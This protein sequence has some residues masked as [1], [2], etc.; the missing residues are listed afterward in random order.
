MLRDR[1]PRVLG[2]R[3][4]LH[5]FAVYARSGECRK[6]AFPNLISVDESDLEKN[7]DPSPVFERSPSSHCTISLKML[8]SFLEGSMKQIIREV[9]FVE[10]TGLH[11]MASEKTLIKEFFYPFL[12]R[13][14]LTRLS[15]WWEMKL[16]FKVLTFT[17]TRYDGLKLGECYTSETTLYVGE[18]SVIVTRR[19]G[20]PC[21]LKYELVVTFINRKSK[22][23]GAILPE[24]LRTA[25][26]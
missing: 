24:R 11:A 16:S 7:P 14:G 8:L 2:F 20:K 18:R 21:V 3:Q 26:S 4:D 22:R 25:L 23:S 17:V 9:K 6:S 10:T 12:F 19:I 1:E 5:R 13:A 15:L